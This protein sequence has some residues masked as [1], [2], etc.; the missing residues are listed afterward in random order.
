MNRGVDVQ[1]GVKIGIGIFLGIALM[2]GG[3]G[4]MGL[5]FSNKVGN[6]LSDRLEEDI[7]KTK[8]DTA[9]I[10]AEN[11]QLDKQREMAGRAPQ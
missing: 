7:R 5:L 11:R 8:E 6:E 2:C 10:E 4:L 9:R 1:K 3:C